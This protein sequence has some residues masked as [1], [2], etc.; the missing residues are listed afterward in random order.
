MLET[1]TKG[2]R[3][4]KARFQGEGVTEQSI[5]AAIRDIRLSL[6]EAD[7]DVDVTRSFID[8]VQKRAHTEV[9]QKTVT[10]KIGGEDQLVTPYH[11]FVAVCQEELEALLGADDSEI[12]F[13]PLGVTSIMMVGLQGAGKTTTTAKIAQWLKSQKKKVMLA[14]ADLQRPAAIEQLQSLGSR[15]NVPVYAETDSD[16]LT[17]CSNALAQA[18]RKKIDVVIFDTAG[19]LAIDKPLMDELKAIKDRV[20]PQE[21]LLVVDA[22]IGQDAVKTASSFDEVLGLTGFVMTKLDGDARGGAALSIRS[23]TGRPIKFLATGETIDALEPF[24]GEGL[25]SRI[26]GMGDV[27]GLVRDLEK[28]VDSDKAEKDAERLLRGDFDMGD[29]VEQISVLRQMG[30]LSDL[31]EK[32]P[33]MQGQGIAPDEKELTKIIAVHDSMTPKERRRPNLIRA[34]TRLKRVSLGCGRQPRD[35]LEVLKKFDMMR[36]MMITLSEQ[37]SFLGKIPGLGQLAQVSKLRGKDLTEIF[38]DVISDEPEEQPSAPTIAPKAKVNRT[39]A[40]KKDTSQDYFADWAPVAQNKPKSKS[41]EKRK[42]QKA[43]RKKSRR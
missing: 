15:I 37:P 39:S 34:Q 1:V 22:M 29:F 12:H 38:G 3:A 17:V 2:F 10:V 14:A 4:A 19:R 16:P 11:Q 9:G 18:S 21:L 24:R 6:L 42:K 20:Q 36:Q 23:V 5:K 8:K 28:V 43:A 35:V 25:A 7:V 32:I 31:V 26:L 41:K 30:P 40:K 33:M 27:V 13:A